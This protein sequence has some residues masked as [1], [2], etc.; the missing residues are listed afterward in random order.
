L[1]ID[2][3]INIDV[4]TTKFE[5]INLQKIYDEVIGYINLK[6]YFFICLRERCL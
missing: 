2:H 5:D 6:E 4:D 1:K 3:C